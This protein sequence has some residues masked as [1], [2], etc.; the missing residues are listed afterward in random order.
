M[1]PTVVFQNGW[2][3]IIYPNEGREPMHVHG[4]K[5]D[6]ECKYWIRPDIFEIEESWSYR[7]TP[8]L[9]REARQ[10]IFENFEEIVEAWQKLHKR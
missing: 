2:H 10:I 9:R 5:G 6:S 8:A 1:S 4:E 7:M 3:F